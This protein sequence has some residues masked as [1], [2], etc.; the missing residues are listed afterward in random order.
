M[1]SRSSDPKKKLSGGVGGIGRV[2]VQRGSKGRG[3][4]YK[5]GGVGGI[6]HKRTTETCPG[7]EGRGDRGKAG[8]DSQ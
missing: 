7:Q 1:V 3:A 2:G 6:K 4:R 5:S 8:F